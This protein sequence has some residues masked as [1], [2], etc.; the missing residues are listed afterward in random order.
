MT[1]DEE[2][3]LDF[4]GMTAMIDPPREEVIAAIKQC[5]TAGIKTVMITGDQPLTATAIAERLGMVEADSKE[6]EA[7]ADLEKLSGEEF[8]SETKHVAVYARVSP[9]QKLNIV[10]ALQTNGEFVAMT[11]DGVND[12]PSLKQADIGIAM[13]I[14]GTDV[15]KE[16]AD[17]ILLDDNFATI[18]KAVRE[19]RRIYENIKKF[20][21]YVLSCNL[22]EILVHLFCAVSWL[23]YSLASHTYSLDQFGNRWLTRTGA[24]GRTC[25][26]RY[27]ES[28]AT[29]PKRKFICRRFNFPIIITGIILTLGALFI[30]GGVFTRIRCK[31]AANS[32]F[33]HFM[34]C[35][36]RKCLIGTLNVSFHFFCRHFCKPWHVGRNNLTVIL[37]LLIVYVP[38]LNTIFK[39]TPLA[40][41][42]MLMILSVTFVC[43][44]LIEVVKLL[45]RKSQLKSAEG[46]G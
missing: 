44:I 28:S 34:F 30:Q 33:Y 32:R 3:D 35:A 2:N 13:G 7:G 29:S 19:G 40:R 5:K 27:Y 46:K 14:T 24:C 1:A 16:A 6:V 21:F 17:M 22:S 23:C 9:E 39:T 10:K 25:R 8:N 45:N 31:N 42:I 38:F 37:Q 36:I 4:L 20:I 11:G 41:N 15:S 18:V 26:E 43:I 12:A